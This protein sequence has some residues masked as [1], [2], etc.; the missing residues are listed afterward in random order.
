MTL[1]LPG[2]GGQ[3]W[4]I[5]VSADGRRMA[6]LSGKGFAEPSAVVYD[7][8]TSRLLA[9]LSP[10]RCGESLRHIA[11]HPEKPILAVSGGHMGSPESDRPGDW[12]AIFL[13]DTQ[14]GKVVRNISFPFTTAGPIAWVP[15]RQALFSENHL[16]D[17]RTGKL[18]DVLGAP[19]LQWAE[20]R[21]SA[22]DGTLAAE[23]RYE[24]GG[25]LTQIETYRR[26]R[27]NGLRYALLARL[28]PDR[29]ER[30]GNVRSFRTQPAFLKNG[31][32]AY[33]RAFL[34]PDGK[35]QRVDLWTCRPNG[36][37]ERKWLSLPLIPAEKP[38]RLP[39]YP[40]DYRR[41]R[42]T[43]VSWSRDGRVLAYVLGRQI[44]VRRVKSPTAR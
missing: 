7:V 38:P 23:V 21:L 19:S 41:Y 43:P 5:A 39:M 26:L 24:R 6:V 11:W 33:V 16:L 35:R 28:R 10:G 13:L 27:G 42:L 36:T 32:L 31:R 37:D 20:A 22:S 14:R 2:T 40:K 44:Y 17:L 9:T 12:L 15:D 34:T 30:T 4:E 8:S 29:D 1:R 18:S 3:I 25:D